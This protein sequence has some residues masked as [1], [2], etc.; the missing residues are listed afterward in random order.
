MI[1]CYYIREVLP[2]RPEPGTVRRSPWFVHRHVDDGYILWPTKKYA[3]TWLRR[4][5][6]EAAIPEVKQALAKQDEFAEL[7]VWAYEPRPRYQSGLDELRRLLS[8][9]GL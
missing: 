4:E 1:K 6:A 5:A 2:E 7:E 3:R 8:F 9:Q